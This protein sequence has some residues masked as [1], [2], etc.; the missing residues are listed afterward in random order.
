MVGDLERDFAVVEDDGAVADVVLPSHI[1]KSAI[2]LT[3]SYYVHG[4][5]GRRE[6]VPYTKY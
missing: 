1:T 5:Q 3:S 6:S 4:W 2:Y